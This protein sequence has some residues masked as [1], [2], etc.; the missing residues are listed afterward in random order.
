MVE[1]KKSLSLEEVWLG[2]LLQPPLVIQ[3]MKFCASIQ[4]SQKIRASRNI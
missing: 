1:K 3:V 4:K 2:L